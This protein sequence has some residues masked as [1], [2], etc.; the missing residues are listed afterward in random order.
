[1]SNLPSVDAFMEDLPRVLDLD[2]GM[3]D[4]GETAATALMWLWNDVDLPSIYKNIDILP[5]SALDILAK[6]FKIDWY[7]YNYLPATKR[8]VIKGSFYIHRHLGTVGAVKRALA[9]VWPPSYIEEWFEYGGEPY[10][11]RAILNG[12]GP[13]PI[14][15]NRIREILDFYK[16]IRSHLEDNGVIVRIS[17]TIKVKTQTSGIHY[18]TR[19]AGTFPRI[20]THGDIQSSV[21]E[22]ET[23][24][25][26]HYYHVPFTN[27]LTSG[28]WPRTN[29]HGNLR[30]GGLVIDTAVNDGSASPRLCG[31]PMD[32]LF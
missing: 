30:N 32:S 9:D 28:E 2:D 29:A 17:C 12:S 16:S 7:N 4:L 5:E 18:H 26:G 20:S 11:F 3:H 14:Y 27:E 19:L 22:V 10:W 23:S 21:I 15:I 13:E 24:R 1:M 31:E 25:S 6:D 8:A